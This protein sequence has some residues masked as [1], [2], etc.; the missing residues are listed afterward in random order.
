MLVVTLDQMA[1]GGIMDQLAGGFHRYSTDGAWLVPHFEKMLYDN[2]ALARLYAEAVPL[3]PAEGFAR[4]ARRTLDFVLERMT[5]A[6]GAFLSAID[7]ETDGHEGAYYTWTAG[8]LDEA[9]PAAEA[10]LFREFYGLEGAPPFEGERYVL[11]Q[12][13]PLTESIEKSGVD[14][15]GLWQQLE[16]GRRALLAARE[17]REHPLIDDKV[18]T[19]WNGLMIG[20]MARTG[21]LLG[22]ARYLDAARGAAAFVIERLGGGT[23]G[24]LRHSYRAGKA[25]VPAFLDDYAFLIEGLLRLHTATGEVLWLER[26]VH[27]AE[28]QETRLGAG[29]RGG[30]FAAGED[31]RLLFRARP[32]YDGAVASG[33][34]MAALNLVE[35]AALT[36]DARWSERA[37]AALLSFGEGLARVPIAHVTLVRALSRLRETELP[38][39]G[40][41]TGKPATPGPRTEP[42]LATAP[43]G[44]SAMEALEDE[45]RDAVEIEARLGSGEDEVWKPFTVD[46]TIRPG[47]HIN[48]NPAPEPELIATTVSG[49]LGPVRHLRYPAGDPGEGAAGGYRGRV[50]IE[51]EIEHRG[52]GAAAV[53]VVFQ[54]CDDR[55]CLPPVSR[56]VRLG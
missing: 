1:R 56:V 44:S 13:R 37:E 25:Q 54:A 10:G 22:E 39:A 35:L 11:H 26:A 32:A 18:L 48:P 47:F 12:P 36:G 34:G 29:D 7:A 19:D 4:V 38:E 14:E 31:P 20:A 3:A 55:R 24:P 43:A 40:R 28:E 2:A 51:G 33:N 50:R 21:E 41:Q 46:L 23:S 8:E 42:A 6:E 45:A 17:R 52:G 9:L 5:S 16:P 30:Y 27:L 15:E 49:V 53:E